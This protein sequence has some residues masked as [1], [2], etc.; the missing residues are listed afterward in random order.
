MDLHE[1]RPSKR[2]KFPIRS[3]NRLEHC[4]YSLKKLTMWH[5]NT[6]ISHLDEN[7]RA[8]SL[9]RCAEFVR[10]AVEAG[11]VILIRCVSAK[12]YGPGLDHVG[13][14]SVGGWQPIPGH[15]HGHM[16]MHNG[17][18]WISDFRQYHG[19]YPGP[20]YRRIKPIYVLYD[21]R[22]RFR[23]RSKLHNL[24]ARSNDDAVLYC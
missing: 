24:L 12:D 23:R 3:K 5:R 11:G 14:R 22:Y 13:F 1:V 15:P 20:A 10:K 17:K 21:I 18:I 2:R 16:A 19:L 7:A 6:A 4:L 9:G 8:Y